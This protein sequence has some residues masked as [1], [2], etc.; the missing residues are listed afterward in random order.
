VDVYSLAQKFQIQKLCRICENF[1]DSSITCSNVLNLL[2]YVENLPVLKEQCMKFLSK[3]SNFNQV[4]SL[5]EFESLKSS[6][7]VE[8]IRLKQIQL[9]KIVTNE[10]TPADSSQ[11]IKCNSNLINIFNLNTI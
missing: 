11:T 5:R 9:N 3:E 1:L 2:C 7:M 8:M 6:L 4:I 10:T